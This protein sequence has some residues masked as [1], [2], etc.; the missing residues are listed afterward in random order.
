MDEAFNS[1]G[2]TREVLVRRIGLLLRTY[3]VCHAALRDVLEIVMGD[4]DAT[5]GSVIA[6]DGAILARRGD[7]E[8]GVAQT[9]A[10]ANV[11]QGERIVCLLRIYGPLVAEAAGRLQAVADELG[12]YFPSID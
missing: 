9:V 7:G 1:H 4:L 2:L 8:N 10:T 5:G 6:P 3:G 11:R 12:R